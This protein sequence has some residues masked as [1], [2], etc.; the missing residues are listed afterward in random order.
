MKLINSKS[1]EESQQ[2]V[3]KITLSGT[4]EGKGSPRPGWPGEVTC[5]EHIVVPK[6]AVSGI[7]HMITKAADG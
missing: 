7:V 6:R 5:V 3:Q 1:S 4:V 2:K